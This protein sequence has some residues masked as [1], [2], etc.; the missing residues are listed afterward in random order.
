MLDK[1][2]F[3]YYIRV[4]EWS[5]TL[6][7]NYDWLNCIFFHSFHSWKKTV[8]NQLFSSQLQC[9]ENTYISSYLFKKNSYQHISQIAFS[10]YS[11]SIA[12]LFKK[13]IFFSESPIFIFFLNCKIH[14]R[15]DFLNWRKTS[16]YPLTKPRFN[17]VHHHSWQ[18]LIIFFFTQISQLHSTHYTF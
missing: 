5:S 3:F 2:Y 10:N 13:K 14:R 1:S 9:I 15:K 17:K 11:S 18:A 6:Y 12:L 16:T 8:L 4:K 7:K